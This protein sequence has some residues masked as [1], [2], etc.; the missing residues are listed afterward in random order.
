MPAV[1]NHFLIINSFHSITTGEVT[2][3]RQAGRQKSAIIFAVPPCV[4]ALSFNIFLGQES[5]YLD[6]QYVAISK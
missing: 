4:T 2:T 3:G 5:N 1:V 6:S